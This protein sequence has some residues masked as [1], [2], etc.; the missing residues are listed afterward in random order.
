[1]GIAVKSISW[2]NSPWSGECYYLQIAV[3]STRLGMAFFMPAISKKETLSFESLFRKSYIYL[4][5][6]FSNF[7]ERNRIQI[8]IAVCK[9]AVP[10][11]L[12]HSGAVT[13]EMPVI[14]LGD[15]LLEY[16]IGNNWT[17]GDA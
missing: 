12:E 1:M 5:T 16:A 11:K 6:N 15:R 3:L 17:S 9:M 14:K 4:D 10:Q 13:V 2:F 7:S 8:A